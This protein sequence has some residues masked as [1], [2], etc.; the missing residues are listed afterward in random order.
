MAT[1]KQ[2]AANRANALRSTGPR[3]PDGKAIGR[4]NALVHGLTAEQ[5]MLEGE[6]PELF[7]TLREALFEEFAPGSPYEEQLTHQVVNVLWRLRRIPAFEAALLSWID[8]QRGELS[9]DASIRVMGPGHSITQEIPERRARL[10]LGRML[11]GGAR[12]RWKCAGFRL[13]LSKL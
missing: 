10:K 3:T 13:I 9:S 2:I 5:L 8:F 12:V 11:E 7:D 1:E 6:D 4:R